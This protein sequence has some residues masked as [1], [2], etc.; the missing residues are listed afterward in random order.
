MDSQG[1]EDTILLIEWNSLGYNR[2]QEKHSDYYY[3]NNL[4]GLERLWT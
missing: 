3:S 1:R 4:F 2:Y